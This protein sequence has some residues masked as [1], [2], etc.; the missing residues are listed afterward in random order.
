MNSATRNQFPFQNPWCCTALQEDLL[1]TP[2][3]V[4][5]TDASLQFFGWFWDA[6]IRTLDEHYISIFPELT[7]EQLQS[8]T[9]P[10][11][12]YQI[13]HER[14]IRNRIVSIEGFFYQNWVEHTLMPG[15]HAEVRRSEHRAEMV[16]KRATAARGCFGQFDCTF[17][18]TKIL[19]ALW[20]V[21]PDIPCEENREG[22]SKDSA[23]ES[24]E[25]N[26]QAMRNETTGRG[27][28]E[29]GVPDIEEN[30]G[31]LKRRYDRLND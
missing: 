24:M 2:P 25:A 9:I 15:G 10:S 13:V 8:Q 6:N 14:T 21:P 19:M 31:R 30:C 18:D 3:D 20:S 28:G 7:I 26:G 22:V 4:A 29:T 23:G 12:F 27:N 17:C 11:I 1:L 16:R 5:S